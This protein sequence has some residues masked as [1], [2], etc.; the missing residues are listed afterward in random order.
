MPLLLNCGCGI[1]FH[2][3]QFNQVSL[4]GQQFALKSRQRLYINGDFMLCLSSSAH[5]LGRLCRS[6]SSSRNPTVLIARI[7]VM[8]GRKRDI[9]LS[10]LLA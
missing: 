10:Q 7:I 5:Q 2:T 4:L 1:L 3:K 9:L 6:F 8:R